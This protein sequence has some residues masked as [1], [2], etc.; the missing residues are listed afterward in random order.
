MP[1][2]TTNGADLYYEAYGDG[3]PIL[4]IHGTPSSVLFWVDAARELADFGRCIIYARRGFPRSEVPQP[5][6]S[7]DLADH[8]EDAAGLLAALSAP[9]AV[10]IGRSTGGL[11]ALALAHRHPDQVR[12]LVL[13]EPAV[14]TVDPAAA[15][16]AD[17]LRRKVLGAVSENPALAAEVVV[18]DALGD[19]AWETFP[20]D[21]KELFAA[22]SPAVLAELRGT[23][24]DLSEEPLDLSAE[25]LAGIHQPT[26]IVSSEDSPEVLRRVDDRLAAAL[27]RTEQALVNGGHLIHPA[28]P[29]VLDFVGR[30]LAP[31]S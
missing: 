18:R 25:E 5:F 12:A 14:F 3:T 7:V 2:V 27:P 8:V 17:Q 1:F 28:H 15:K 26:L 9:P 16:W 24:L 13:L 29:A 31:P 11:V 10:V 20:V 4:G 21:L 30:I 23:G 22:A 6:E 19:A